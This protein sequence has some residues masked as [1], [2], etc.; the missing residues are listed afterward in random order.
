MMR[1]RTSTPRVRR[2]DDEDDDGADS[3]VSEVLEK[4][5]DDGSNLDI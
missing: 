4:A 1:A 3:D 2:R 5:K